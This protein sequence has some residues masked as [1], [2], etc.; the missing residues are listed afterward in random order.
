VAW[1]DELMLLD[2]CSGCPREEGNCQQK[3]ANRSMKKDHHNNKIELF[4]KLKDR[5]VFWS[6]AKSITFT[7][8]GDNILCE[9][10]LKYG[11]FDDL[12]TL[13]VIYEESYVKRV[14]EENSDIKPEGLYRELAKLYYELNKG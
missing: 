6:Y 10:A 13:F 9:Y 8:L 12:K 2:S 5:G 7:D 14:W 4:E 11:D 1:R 3:Y